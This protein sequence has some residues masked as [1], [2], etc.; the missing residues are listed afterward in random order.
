MSKTGMFLVKFHHE[1]SWPR[2]IEETD[3]EILNFRTKIVSD[4]EPSDEMDLLYSCPNMHFD[5]FTKF[6]FSGIISLL[7]SKNHI[8]CSYR[9]CGRFCNSKPRPN[10]EVILTFIIVNL[11]WLS[12]NVRNSTFSGVFEF[13]K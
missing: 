10:L 2:P 11:K 5:T 6:K 13:I 8:G 1:L 12:M 7:N 9:G 4:N 3:L